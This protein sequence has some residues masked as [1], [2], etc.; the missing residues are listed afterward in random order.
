MI[1][2]VLFD[3]SGVLYIGDAAL[4][5]ALDS[6]EKLNKSGIPMRFVTNTTR[7]PRKVILNKLEN[8]GFDISGDD[9][10]TAPIATHT[11]L[12]SNNLSPFLLVHPD[13]E[14]DFADLV[15]DEPNAVVLGDAAQGFSYDNM[16]EAFRLLMEG[17][18]LIAMGKNQY[19][20]EADGLSLD[21]GPFVVALEFAANTESIIIGKPAQAFFETA[22]SSLGC[23]TENVVMIG[24]DVK[25]DVIGGLESGLQ[26]I[27]VRTGKYQSGDEDQLQGRGVCVEDISAAVNWIL[28]QL[29]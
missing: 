4:P 9:L 20:R 18:P 23:Q 10:F 1:D 25:S 16:N 11:Y 21:M 13:L 19:F 2:A 7:S 26:G 8:M 17:A 15:S 28:T 5:G 6:I 27:L 24:D 3:L 22:V 29:N 14:Q 12:R